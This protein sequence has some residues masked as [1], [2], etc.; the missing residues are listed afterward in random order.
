MKYTPEELI[1]YIHEE[2]LEEDVVNA[3]FNNNRGFMFTPVQIERINEKSGAL[4]AKLEGFDGE[5]VE[6]AD[7]MAKEDIELIN[8]NPE[9]VSVYVIKYKDETEL[10]IIRVGD[11][12]QE[13]QA[14]DSLIEIFLTKLGIN[15]KGRLKAIIREGNELLD[16]WIEAQ[17][18]LERIFGKETLTKWK[19]DV[20]NA[21]GASI[22]TAKK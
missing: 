20:I 21:G 18:R 10:C 3:M 16:D 22:Q 8:N 13:E 14:L 12:G 17:D 1:G 11:K 4:Y 7:I 9:L 2:G 15:T 19:E 6:I 5:D